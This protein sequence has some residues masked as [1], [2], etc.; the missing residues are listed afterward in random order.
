MITA[1]APDCG[2]TGE[3]ILV[4]VSCFR[5]YEIAEDVKIPIRFANWI[6]QTALLPQPQR[7]RRR[8]P[9]AFLRVMEQGENRFP[10]VLPQLL[11]C[12]QRDEL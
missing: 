2:Q 1:R 8:C 5:C 12:P 11:A 3:L 4:I 6:L 9:H 10:F 7:D